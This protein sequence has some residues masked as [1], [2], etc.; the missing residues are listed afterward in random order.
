M[1]ENYITLPIEAA[2]LAAPADATT[3]YLGSMA[4]LAPQTTA[5]LAKIYIPKSGKIKAAFL[6]WRAATAGT[7]ESI[8]AY[9]RK[10]DATDYLI[11]TVAD[12][13][14]FKHFYNN[15]MEIPVMLL[16]YIEIKVVCPTW[17]TNPANVTFG[18]VLVLE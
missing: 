17:V 8:S 1:S 16:D 4:G 14:A 3:Y 2:N 11:K 7:N 6:A 15:R 10:N 12:T 18:G 9:I 13:N 5:T